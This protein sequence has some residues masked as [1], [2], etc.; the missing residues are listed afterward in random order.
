MPGAAAVLVDHCL[1]V[2]RSHAAPL[3]RGLVVVAAAARTSRQRLVEVR[4]KYAAVAVA[5][6]VVVVVGEVMAAP[7]ILWAAAAIG[8]AEARV[9]WADRGAAVV[10]AENVTLLA[11]DGLPRREVCLR[12]VAGTHEV[13]AA[14]VGESGAAAETNAAAEHWERTLDTGPAG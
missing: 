4:S 11:V 14:M 5:V 13:G 3:V 6:A 10:S 8:V 9:A 12:G 1:V 7:R 2:Q